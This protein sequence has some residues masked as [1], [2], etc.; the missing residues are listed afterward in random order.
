MT[1]QSSEQTETITSGE[2][3]AA[4]APV[5][6]TPVAAKPAPVEKKSPYSAFAN[7][8]KASSKASSTAT[9]QAETYKSMSGTP[10]ILEQTGEYK[11]FTGTPLLMNNPT[12]LSSYLGLKVLSN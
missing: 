3:E 4:V 9:P 8:P 12:P 7:A 10:L 5:V 6:E 1:N 2:S 11:S